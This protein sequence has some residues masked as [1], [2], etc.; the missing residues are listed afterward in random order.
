MTHWQILI[1][2]LLVAGIFLSVLRYIRSRLSVSSKII[3]MLLRAGWIIGL[4]LA[5]WEPTIQFERFE[6]SRM[7][8][9]V[10]IDASISMQN[11]SPDASVIPFL[12]MLSSL[13]SSAGGRVSFEYFLFGDSTRIRQSSESVTFT[14]SRSIFPNALD[15]TGGRFSN[16]MIIISDAHWTNP[17]KASDIFPRSTIHYVVLPNATPNPFI[18]VSHNAPETTPSDSVFFVEITAN[19]YVRESG[20]AVITLK[21]GNRVVRTETAE[22]EQGYFSRVIRVRTSNSR[23]GRRLYTVEAV[24]DTA[25]P[26]SVSNFVHQTIPHFLTYSMYSARPTLDRRYLTQA[27]AANDFFRARATAPDVLFLFD[28]D[29][30]AARMVRNLP[31]HATVVFAG[32][33]PCNTTNIP[34][35]SITVRPV[36]DGLLRTNVDLRTIPPPQE[37]ITCRPLPVSGMRRLLNA[38]INQPAASAADAANNPDNVP[39]LFTGRF[40]GRQSLFAPVRGIWRWDFWPMA[41]DRAESELF[42]FSNTMLSLAKEILLDNIA[43]QLILYPVGM[44]TETDSTRFMMSLPAAIPIF[45]SVDLALQIQGEGINIDTV[46]NY[47]PHGLNNQPL[48]FRPLPPGKYN[49]SSTLNSG[50]VRAAF[51]DSFTVNKDMSELSVSAQNTQYLQEFARPLDI[52]EIDAVNYLF[53]SWNMRSTEKHTITETMR[54]HR[55]WLLLGIV[56]MILAI[57]L[58]LRRIWGV[59]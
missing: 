50:A 9:P 42:G 33:L 30:T 4:L 24:I 18:T 59:D 26:P 6:D 10:L 21:E 19:G 49:I 55:S 3:L 32:C 20:S 35:P 56:F 39:I 44:L 8:I 40:M 51:S 54:F 17:R 25:I 14:D 37:I 53:D 28:W 7:R 57:E 38:S 13:Q 48:S 45:E 29:T 22:I 23:P 58:V 27:L 52:K 36:E 2:V 15:E 12:D 43:D 1:T 47:I 16:D 46:L 34:A 31:R 41:S 11:F 5:F